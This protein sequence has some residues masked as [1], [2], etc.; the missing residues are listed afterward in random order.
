MIYC[1]IPSYIGISGN[2]NMDQKTKESLNLHLTN[3]PIQFSNF[4]RLI[5]R[6]ILNN[7]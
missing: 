1:W 2:E 7:W 6:Y 3:F 5:N 4:K